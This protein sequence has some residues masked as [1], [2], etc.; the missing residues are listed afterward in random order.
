[1]RRGDDAAMV[2]ERSGGTS[3]VRERRDSAAMAREHTR[4]EGDW[5]RREK[6]TASSSFSPSKRIM[7]REK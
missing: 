7:K 2:R 6:G 4:E 5:F 3:M 1:M